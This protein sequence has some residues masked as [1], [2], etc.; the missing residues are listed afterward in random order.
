MVSLEFLLTKSFLPH[1]GP[2]VD[3]ASNRNEY[4]D[5]FL[6][7]KAAGEYGW[8][9]YH[10]HVPIVLKSGSFNLLETSGPVQVCNG[11]PL[12]LHFTLNV[13]YPFYFSL[14]SYALFFFLS[15]LIL[16]FLS[17]LFYLMSVCTVELG[18]KV[19]KGTEYFVSLWTSVVITEEY[20][21]VVKS[22]ELIGTTAYLTLYTRCRINRCRYNRVRLNFVR[23]FVSLFLCFPDFIPIYLD[24]F[25]HC[26]LL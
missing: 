17:F 23:H 9:P 4:Q 3:S 20:N 26:C 21:V 13:S 22:E 24:I 18:C 1:C 19:M 5:Y 7:V 15:F 11:I 25:L 14:L 12:S 16:L 2:G 8:Q 6:G 10:L